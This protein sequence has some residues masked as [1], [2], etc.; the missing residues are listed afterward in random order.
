MNRF[1][2]GEVNDAQEVIEAATSWRDKVWDKITDTAMWES[3][4]FSGI[5]IAIILVITRLFVRLIYKIIDKSLDRREKSRLSVN[6]RRLVTV[7]ELLK[8]VTTI[9]SNFIMIMLIL[10]EIGVNLG[11]LI[12][13]AGVVGLAIGF[14]AQS[15]VKDVITG[16]FVIFEDQFAVGDVVQIAGVKGTVEMIGLRST[17][18]IS[19]TGEVQIIPNGMI[20]TVTNYSINNSLALVDLPFSNTRKLDEALG[21]LKDA[22]A[23]LKE[24]NSLLTEIP[25]VVGIQSLTTSEYV[26]RISAE[27]QPG[28]RADLERQIK[29]YAK[30]ALEQE[31]ARMAAREQAGGGA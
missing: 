3:L 2:V 7:G 14:G 1:L 30:A 31:E 6:P 24:D 13:G 28:V 19:W 18:L 23:Q 4:L 5:R 20:T 22:M 21:L 15:L 8:N 16:F 9:V 12:A 11:P 26:V 10:G 25:H 29:A 17:R 27:C